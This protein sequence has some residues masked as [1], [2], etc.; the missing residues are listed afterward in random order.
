MALYR[1]FV[2]AGRIMTLVVHDTSKAVE[3]IV[4]RP[5]TQDELDT[6]EYKAQYIPREEFVC[7][8]RSDPS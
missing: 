1:T 4:G 5:A 8:R 2:M 6:E 3:V 7:Q